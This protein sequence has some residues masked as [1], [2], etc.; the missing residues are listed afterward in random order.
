MTKD[1]LIEAHDGWLHKYQD[2]KGSLKGRDERLIRF[3][4]TALDA[5]T[6]GR[7]ALHVAQQ[8]IEM[9]LEELRKR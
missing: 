6:D 2:L 3:L 8:R 9:C 5:V 4:S 1:E 7:S